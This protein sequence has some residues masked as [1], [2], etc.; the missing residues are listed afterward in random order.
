MKTRTLLIACCTAGA[1]LLAGCTSAYTNSKACEQA[2]RQ[3][4][5][6]Q[7]TDTLKIQHTGSGIDGRRVVVEGTLEHPQTASE[8]AAAKPPETDIFKAGLLA[9]VMAAFTSGKPKKTVVGAAVECTYNAGGQSEFRWLAP[10]KL[11]KTD[12]ESDDETSAK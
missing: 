7:T 3:A 4:A 6:E 8:A 5:S 1:A 9:P 11:A 10:A 12:E 2:M